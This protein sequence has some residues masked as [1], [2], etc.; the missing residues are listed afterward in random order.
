MAK[1]IMP[2]ILSVEMVAKSKLFSIE[3]LDLEFSNGVKRTYERMKRSGRQAVM[4]V[5][6]TEEGGDLLLVREY[7]AGTEEYELGFPKGLVDLGGETPQQA[8]NRELKEEIG[9]GARELT[10]LKQVI[11]APSYFSAKMTLFLVEDL[12]LESLEGGDEPEPLE[13]VRWPLSQ[14][15]DLLSHLDFSEAR[16]IAALML[17]QRHI[18]NR[19]I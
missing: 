11:L 1:K 17:A 3:S 19:E 4:M 12:Y 13:V 9:F 5:P 16:S 2:K 10:P 6:L 7:A 8:A 15:E 18:A 14:A